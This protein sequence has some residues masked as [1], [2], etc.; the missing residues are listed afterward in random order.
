MLNHKFKKS[1]KATKQ[2]KHKE[3]QNQSQQLKPQKANFK[4]TIKETTEKKTSYFQRS[5]SFA[6]AGFSKVAMEMRRQWEQCP[7]Q[8]ETKQRKVR[9]YFLKKES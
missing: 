4:E 9:C 2:N 6:T 1:K 7:Q 5:N 8:A 3:I